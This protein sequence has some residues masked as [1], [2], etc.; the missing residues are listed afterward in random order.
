MRGVSRD[1]FCALED[2]LKKRIPKGEVTKLA[3]QLN[4]FGS[5]S[6]LA[7]KPSGLIAS[8]HAARIEVD[9]YSSLANDDLLWI[10]FTD[11]PSRRS[12][13]CTS[14]LDFQ[15]P[16]SLLFCFGEA[17]PLTPCIRATAGFA[18]KPVLRRYLSSQWH[19]RPSS[20]PQPV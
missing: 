10:E 19:V 15:V 12:R 8:F 13:V 7:K 16:L 20:R 14:S 5:I 1:I 3:T 2:I 11:R 4:S 17:R 18:F 9:G 6:A